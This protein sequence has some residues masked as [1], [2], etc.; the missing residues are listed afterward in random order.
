MARLAGILFL[1]AAT[2]SAQTLFR[3]DLNGSL[4]P[5]WTILHP[6][7]SYYSIGPSNLDLRASSGD[8]WH[9]RTDYKNLF[10]IDNP[11]SG[12]FVVTVAL[13]RFEPA[14]EL[15]A[16]FDIVAYDDDDNHVRCVYGHL[17]VG[18]RSFD[19]ASEVAGVYQGHGLTYVDC[20]SAPFWIRMRK[21]GTVYSQFWSTDG[22]NFLPASVAFS[23]GDGTPRKLGFMAIVD[24]TAS[25][26]ACVDSFE[27]DG[28]M[29][30]PRITG[31]TRG[32][33]TLTLAIDDLTI[34][35]VARIESVDD[36]ASGIW[37]TVDQFTP[38][39][40]T[41]NWPVAVPLSAR[42]WFYRVAEVY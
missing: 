35:S 13:Q 7:A 5:E 22:V 23:Y 26:R 1:V 38:S 6:D 11:T 17:G 39:G 9:Y 29:R 19:N 33:T 25:S 37:L 14:A 4:R 32:E 8:I 2:G 30:S 16:Q 42:R 24:P 3:D 28:G 21:E 20:G 36:L 15:H 12:D 41:T 27:V 10:L 18:A 31:I 40:G 34:G